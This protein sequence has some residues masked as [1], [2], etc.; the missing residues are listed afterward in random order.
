MKGWEWDEWFDGLARRDLMV[1]AAMDV[2]TYSF[3]NPSARCM[4]SVATMKAA[5]EELMVANPQF[6]TEF[7]KFGWSFWDYERRW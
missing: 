1:E 7:E 6:R 5:A 3:T 4:D 2:E